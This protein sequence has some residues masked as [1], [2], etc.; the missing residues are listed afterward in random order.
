[1]TQRP[2]S[3]DNQ[4]H[5]QATRKEL[6][7][8]APGQLQS[9]AFGLDRLQFRLPLLRLAGPELLG[10]AS[11]DEILVTAVKLA[12]GRL[13]PLLELPQVVHASLFHLIIR[14]AEALRDVLGDL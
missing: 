1:M 4:A 6:S 5:Q 9:V 2:P 7:Q 10:D 3:R 12:R 8:K 14:G 13:P 11:A